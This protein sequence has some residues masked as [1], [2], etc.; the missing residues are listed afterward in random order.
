MTS[1]QGRHA[2]LYDLFYEAK[3][4]AGEA[5]FVHDCLVRFGD[6]ASEKVVDLAC[7][8]GR[9]AIEL[10][11][12]GHR[13]VGVDHSQSMLKVARATAA[14]AGAR[15]EF[16]AGDLRALEVPGGPFD[17]ASCLFDSI[18]Y[19]ETNEALTLALRG[20]H[21]ALR[22]G[23]LFVFEFWHAAAMLRG[24][25]PVRVRRW[26]RPDG[27]VLR[28]SETRLDCERQL[29]KVSYLVYELRRDGTYSSFQET[30]TNRYFLVQEMAGWLTSAGFAPLAWF[31]GFSFEG[32]ISEDTWHIVAVARRE[33]RGG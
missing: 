13:V 7:G 3:D 21:R 33:E 16:H 22:P 11:R 20:V 24:A 2:E 8:T 31:A 32:R 30:Q 17:A 28:I 1:Y 27:E 6:G 4:Y 14:A 23:G 26:S 5:R 18:G 9:H 25:E 29:G 10:E 19:V 15:A 12:L